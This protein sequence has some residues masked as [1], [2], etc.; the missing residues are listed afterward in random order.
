[1]TTAPANSR[2]LSIRQVE[3]ADLLDVFRIEKQCF[4]QPWPY[5]AFEQFLDESGFLLAERD[6]TVVGY[7]V[8]DIVPNYGRDI[9]HIKDL[10]V[11]PEYRGQGVGRTLLQRA[12]TDL[13]VTNTA[14]VKL[15]VREGNDPALALYRDEGFEPMRRVPRYYQDGEAA[16][17]MVLDLDA[18]ATG[19]PTGPDLDVDVDAG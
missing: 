10:A 16:L 19:T 3:R 1:V 5:A 13:F 7:V 4:S 18:W 17:V 11:H 15:E 8:A 14:L 2:P 12:L 6:G 9:G